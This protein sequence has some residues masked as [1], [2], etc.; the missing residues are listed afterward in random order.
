[1]DRSDVPDLEEPVAISQYEWS[2]T[3]P[4]SAVV[5]TVAEATDRDPTAFGPLHTAVDPD[6]LDA[7]VLESDPSDRTVVSFPFDGFEITVRCCGEVVVR[8]PSD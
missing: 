1:M 5:E 4:S 7:L 3:R 6:A 2:A 8:A